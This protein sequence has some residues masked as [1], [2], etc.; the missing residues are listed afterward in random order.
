MAAIDCSGIVLCPPRDASVLSGGLAATAEQDRALVEG[1][2]DRLR[3][4]VADLVLVADDPAAYLTFDALI[5]RPFLWPFSLLTALHAGLCHCDGTHALAVSW[6]QPLVRSSV[7]QTLLDAA[8]PR[9]DLVAPVLAEG[10]HP[11]PAIYA[12]GI[13]DR[14]ERLAAGQPERLENLFKKTRLKAISEKR[15]R[16]NDPELISFLNLQTPEDR[17]NLQQRLARPARAQG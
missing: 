13:R 7:L 3:P 17:P 10:S 5:V 6:D 1:L 11:I 16:Q 9:Y 8:A 2:V 4:L 14:V 12:V 15:L